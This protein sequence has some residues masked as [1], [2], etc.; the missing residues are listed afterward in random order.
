MKKTMN[1]KMNNQMPNPMYPIMNNGMRGIPGLPQIIE[2]S[3][4]IPLP[5]MTY[6]QNPISMIFGNFKR[7]RMETAM[8][9]EAR[10]AEHSGKAVTAKLDTIQAIITFSAR[11][12][13]S[14]GEYEHRKELREQAVQ[15]EIKRLNLMELEAQEKQA[16]IQLIQYKT[17]VIA[18]EVEMYKLENQI[19]RKQLQQMLN[20]EEGDK[21]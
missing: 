17:A 11:V 9:V 6:D 16:N 10:M 3:L 2:N 21:D 18:E 14:F 4:P 8:E 7:K 19:K 20:E 12:Q 1:K 5:R 15:Q 13:D